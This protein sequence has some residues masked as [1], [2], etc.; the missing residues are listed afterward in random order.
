MPRW[1][2][3]S[4]VAKQRFACAYWHAHSTL[5]LHVRPLRREFLLQREQQSCAQ[6][7]KH[8]EQMKMQ[9]LALLP[10]AAFGLPQGPKNS[11]NDEPPKQN[12]SSARQLML[13]FLA[14][15]RGRLMQ[16]HDSSLHFAWWVQ[17]KKPKR[18]YF[19]ERGTQSLYRLE[20]SSSI[21]G[22]YPL[23][24]TYILCRNAF[25]RETTR[26]SYE[27]GCSMQAPSGSL[28]LI[29]LRQLPLGEL[30]NPS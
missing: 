11:K 17:K 14:L 6:T 24:S 19:G 16:H 26:L 22:S 5:R 3:R 28:D 7:L 29:A 20:F 30:Q 12:A 27:C 10:T 21:L 9:L 15:R 2:A 18:N 23:F 1:P 8:A 13:F 25:I 4:S